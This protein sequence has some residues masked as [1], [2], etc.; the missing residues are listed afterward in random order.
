ML[1]DTHPAHCWHTMEP[2]Q[3]RYEYRPLPI[4]EGQTVRKCCKCIDYE[5]IPV[6][7]R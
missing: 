3:A 2:T 4:P 7:A 6:P 1:S 5:V